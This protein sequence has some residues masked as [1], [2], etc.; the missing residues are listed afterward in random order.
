[1]ALTNLPTAQLKFALRD[2]TG[3][4]GHLLIHVPYATLA[5]V[6][7]TAADAISAVIEAVTGCAF[8]GYSL[9]Y[10]KNETTPADPADGSRVENKGV[11][12]WRTADGRSTTFTV[13]GIDEAV[14]NV[15]GSID[16][17]NAEIIALVAVVEDVG[18]I[19]AG[20]S[21]SDIVS[22]LSAYQRFSG[23]TKKQLPSAR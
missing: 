12:Q 16:R 2:E 4:V 21:G 5:A 22:L 18:A 7:V 17:S 9:T 23:S 20:A 11:F 8:L 13:P 6:A 10:A 3:S 19:F 15:D 1:M 14:L